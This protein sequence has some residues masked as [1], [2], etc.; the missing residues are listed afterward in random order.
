MDESTLITRIRNA[1]IIVDVRNYKCST[2][3]HMVHNSV[4]RQTLSF[5]GLIVSTFDTKQA[6]I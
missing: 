5:I 6:K 3:G 1:N 4:N 2:I